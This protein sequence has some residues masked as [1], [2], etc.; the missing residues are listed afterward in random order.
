LPVV[1]KNPFRRRALCFDRTAAC[2]AARQA[3]QKPCHERVD[4][5]PQARDALAHIFGAKRAAQRRAY[6]GAR[7]TVPL[8]AMFGGAFARL[9][10]AHAANGAQHDDGHHYALDAV[11]PPMR[12]GLGR[13]RERGELGSGV[14]KGREPRQPQ[15]RPAVKPLEAMLGEGFGDEA[16]EVKC[17]RA[18]DRSNYAPPIPRI[19]A[20]QRSVFK[21]LFS[22]TA[23]KVS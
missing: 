18:G 4:V 15:H 16:H 1:W 22:A 12:N 13:S 8:E 10:A 23:Q 11:E 21:V 2:E 6:D 20:P 17:M 5:L 7:E 19:S 3:A 9:R 14:E